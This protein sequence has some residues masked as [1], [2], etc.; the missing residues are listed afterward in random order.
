V[1]YAFPFASVAVLFARNSPVVELQPQ[2]RQPL[3]SQIL[4]SAA[5]NLIAGLDARC[6]G[7]SP[8]TA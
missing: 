4:K 5:R 6:S 3:K 8:A 7:L 1:F 2:L